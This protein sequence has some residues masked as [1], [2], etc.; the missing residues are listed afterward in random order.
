MNADGTPLSP[1]DIPRRRYKGATWVQEKSKWRAQMNLGD[2][3][4]LHLGYYRDEESAARAYDKAALEH[5]GANVTT[6]FPIQDYAPGGAAALMGTPGS[7]GQMTTG[8]GTPAMSLPKRGRGRPKGSTNK[9]SEHG[10]HSFTE[11]VMMAP[12]ISPNLAPML[13]VQSAIRPL[14][15]PRPEDAVVG[16]FAAAPLFASAPQAYDPQVHHPIHVHHPHP[17]QHVVDYGADPASANSGVVGVGPPGVNVNN[18]NPNIIT[19]K[20][21][22]NNTLNMT[23]TSGASAAAAVAAATAVVAAAQQQQQQSQQQQQQHHVQSDGNGGVSAGGYPASTLPA[24]YYAHY[25][26]AAA[27]QQAPQ[28]SGLPYVTAGTYPVMGAPGTAPNTGP[29]AAFQQ[30]PHQYQ[31]Q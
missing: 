27:N 14:G 9:K 21:I 30:W 6:N 17:Q 18:I 20:D 25:A 29:R 12:G 13:K 15:T 5:F 3:K 28:Q 1:T 16:G 23:P 7:S 31:Y 26:A 4:K 11:G 24:E 2:G 8:Y 10:T 19:P 22:N